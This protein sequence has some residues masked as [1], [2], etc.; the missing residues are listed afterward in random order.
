MSPMPGIFCSVEFIELLIRP[1]MA[2]VCPSQQ[3][4][5]RFPVRR[6]LRARGCGSRC[7][8]T[9]LAKSSVLTSGAPSGARGR[10]ESSA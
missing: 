9:P 10:R 1:A 4:D 6:V 3:L 7:S 2:N 8:R 5:L